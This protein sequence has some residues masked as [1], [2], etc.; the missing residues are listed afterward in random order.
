[1]I[2][3]NCLNQTMAEFAQS[4]NPRRADSAEPAERGLKAFHWNAGLRS[5][6]D[7]ISGPGL[8]IFVSFA[9]SLGLAKERIGVITSISSFACLMQVVSIAAV[10]FIPDRK[11][12]ILAL[13]LCDALALIVMALAAPFLPAGMRLWALGAGVFLAGAAF[14]LTRPLS[15]DWLASSIPVSLRAR[16]LGR[17]FQVIS[18]CTIVAMLLAGYVAERIAK[19]DS[20]GLGLALAGGGVFGALSI[21]AL[22][23]APMRA[24][25]ALVRIT[26]KDAC[27]AL[28]VR[29]FRNYL[30]GF[31]VYNI[32]FLM[33]VPYYQVFNLKVLH[34]K[35]S[36]IA[37]VA[38]GYQGVKLLVTGFCGRFIHRHGIRRTLWACGPLYVLFFLSYLFC[39]PERTWPLYAAWA[40]VGVADAAWSIAAMVALYDAVPDVPGRPVYFA[41]ANVLS[42]GIFCVGGLAAIPLLEGLQNTTVQIGPFA[43]GQFQCLYALCFLMMIPG[44]CAAAFFPA[45]EKQLA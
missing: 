45:R 10:N 11:R 28:R 16:Y 35:E 41:I 6:Y 36:R 26:W 22:W 43:L 1:M 13:G 27:E 5:C 19:T 15:D 29:P 34:M 30:V 33:A 12:F 14:H 38:I 39:A 8:F 37:Y 4:P 2:L 40:M 23:R 21:V 20:F 7:T 42:I 25:S 3:L 18:A 31:F 44:M 9:L 32:P 17:R 24:Q